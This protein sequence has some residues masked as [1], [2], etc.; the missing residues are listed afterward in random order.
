M[1]GIG[2]YFKLNM[3]SATRQTTG[4]A[5]SCGNTS[6]GCGSHSA[7]TSEPAPI[8]SSCGCGSDSGGCGSYI[9]PEM[10]DQE[11]FEAAVDA[12]IGQETKKDGFDQVFEVKMDRRTS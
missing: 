9:E 1:S 4:G 10:G 11:F 5:C 2:K 3:N 12:S 7:D 6:G 8:K